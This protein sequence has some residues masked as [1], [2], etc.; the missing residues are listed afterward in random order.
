MSQK[1]IKKNYI[2]NLFYQIL[3]LLTPLIT[4]PYLSRV[5]GADG[6]GTASYADS[7]VS[8]FLLFASLGIGIHGQREVSYVQDDLYKRSLV[9]WNTKL[10]SFCT[11]LIALVAYLMFAMTQENR[12]IYLILALSLLS[13]AVDVTWFFQ[14]MEEFVKIV[15]R[16]A[17]LK[18]ANVGYI[19]LAI[20]SAEDLPLYVMSQALFGLLG[21]LSLWGYLPKYITRVSLTELRPFKDL[22][23]I[24]S[25]FLP[26]VAI[27]VYTVLDKTMIGVITQDA[28]QNGYYEQAL[29]ISKMTLTVAASITTVMIPRI[30]YYFEK[31]DSSEVVRLICQSFR[32]LWFL[33][34]PL[35]IGLVMV[36]RNFVPWFFGVGYEEVADLLKILAF[37]IPIIG[38]SGIIGTQYWVPTKRQNLVTKTVILGA[39]VN[40]ALNSFLISAWQSAGAAVASV[41]A[42]CTVTFAQLY[43]VRKELPLQQI[44]HDSRNYVISAGVMAVWLAILHRILQPSFLNTMT[45]VATGALV[46]FIVLLFLR[47]VFF[48]SNLK[49]VFRKIFRKKS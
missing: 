11:S 44:F 23:T 15:L 17:I 39:C 1:N 5:L 28:F 13:S 22:K 3:Q 46:Y 32:F 40:F 4:A 2:Y 10:L 36:A 38:V 41:A 47:D 12:V 19:F 45:M 26:T 27:Q 9:F 35:C 49:T 25:L 6:I 8:Y 7:I 29:K 37:L 48:V 21:N 14:G 20:H 31:E 18:L 33:G 30:G 34:L 16:N 24:L 43:L 42:E